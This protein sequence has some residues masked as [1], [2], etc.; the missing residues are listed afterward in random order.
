MVEIIATAESIDQAQALIEAGVDTLYVGEDQYGLRLPASFSESEI[1]EITE[2]AHKNGKRVCVAVNALM[3]NDRI[4]KIAPYL[5][6]LQSIAVDS[7]TVG[8]PGVIHILKKEQLQLPFVYDAQTM[9]TSAKQINFWVKRGAEGAVL[10]REL[11]WE[12]LQAIRPQVSVPMEVLVYGATCIHQSKRP[13]VKNYFNF[14]DQEHSSSKEKNLYLSEYRNDEE[15]YSIYEDING[16]HIFAT[17]DVNLIQHLDQLFNVGLTQWKLDGIFTKGERFIAIASLFVQAKEALENG[18]WSPQLMK[19][20]NEQLLV[21][22]P[23]ERR[24]D[25]GFF[26]KKPSDVQ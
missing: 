19:H 21:H 26:L 14:T 24:L 15:H 20:L 5:H 8:D 7:I 25:E 13:L 3:H 2:L 16:T 17:Y 12:E 10:S 1:K 4:E 6:F 18:N 11:T 22:H 9:V 23:K